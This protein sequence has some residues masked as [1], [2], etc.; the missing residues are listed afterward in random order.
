MTYTSH[1]PSQYLHDYLCLSEWVGCIIPYAIHLQHYIEENLQN[2]SIFL[3]PELLAR[4]YLVSSSIL[5]DYI[6]KLTTR[7]VWEYTKDKEDFFELVVL[8]GLAWVL[9][10]EDVPMIE[11]FVKEGLVDLNLTFL[12]NQ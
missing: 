8:R 12:K 6:N 5:Q 7:M 9:L 1:A 2:G 10:H 4:K 3:V 11:Q